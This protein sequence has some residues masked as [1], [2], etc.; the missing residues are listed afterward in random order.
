LLEAVNGLLELQ[1]LIKPSEDH[2]RE[3]VFTI[4]EFHEYAQRLEQARTIAELTSLYWISD[5]ITQA[6]N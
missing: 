3:T 6:E 2:D 1:P 5:A 4:E